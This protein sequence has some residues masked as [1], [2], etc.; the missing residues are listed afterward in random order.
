MA[1]SLG[2]PPARLTQ[3][4]PGAIWVHAVSVGE[5][6]LAVPLVRRLRERFP[7]RAIVFSTSTPTGQ[8][9]AQEKLTSYCDQIF[10]APFDFPWAV[11]A[12]MR[13][14]KPALLLVLE[15]EIWPN[16]FREAKRHGTSVLLANGRIS[17]RS[18]PRYRSLRRF[19]APT[20]AQC[21][22]VLTQSAQDAERFVAAGAPAD[23]VRAAGNL[24]YDFEPGA[25][26]PPGAVAELLTRLEPSPVIL[27][28]STREGEEAMVARAFAE[29]AQKH[30]RALL[31]VAPRHPQ[32][33]DEAYETLCASGL[34]VVR[35]SALGE[36]PALPAILLLDSL[37]ELSSLY[38]SASVVFVGGSLNGWGGHNVL[39]PALFEK[40]VVVGPAMQNFRAVADR[41]LA[42][43]AL[44]Q[45]DDAAGLAPALGALLYD[46]QRAAQ[47]GARGRAV[48]EAER[49]ATGRVVEQAAQLL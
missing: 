6:L 34:P 29:L 21:D 4:G 41:L 35:R 22:A 48:A 26:E 19:F 42:A 18:E 36:P 25:A 40:P 14:V 5:A 45:I 11:R 49:G 15:T 10:Y 37:G 16:L 9:I 27:A 31:M 30:P 28:G 8:D 47:M 1:E 20:L 46:P 32:R 38:A 33:F 39:E 13:A 23:A 3:P 17:D 2:F 24:K 44:V 7:G 43:D 12:T